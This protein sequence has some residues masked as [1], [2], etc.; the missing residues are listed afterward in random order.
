[1]YV[2]QILIFISYL[3]FYTSLF[4]ILV[5]VVGESLLGK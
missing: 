4:K 1:M 5:V 3:I 2:I